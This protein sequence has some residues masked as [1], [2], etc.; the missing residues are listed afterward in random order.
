MHSASSGAIVFGSMVGKE[1]QNLLEKIEDYEGIS[2][3][4]CHLVSF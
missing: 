4:I 1:C 3:K 2:D